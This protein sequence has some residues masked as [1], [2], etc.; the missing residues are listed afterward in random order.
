MNALRDHMVRLALAAVGLGGAR[1]RASY[2]ALVAPGEPEHIAHAFGEASGCALVVRGLLLAAG[3]RPGT[4]VA[5]P[6]FDAS[7]NRCPR[8]TDAIVS[9]A[10]AAE[11]LRP[12][13]L[14]SPQHG[15]IVVMNDYRAGSPGVGRVHL[16]IVVPH[17]PRALARGATD[18]DGSTY[19]RITTVD[20]GERDGGAMGPQLVGRKMRIFNAERSGPPTSI[21][22]PLSHVIDLDAFAARWSN[23]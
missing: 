19:V 1:D 4:L 23:S 6:T 18:G 21:N 2:L 20:G 5:R 13:S 22:G 12:G 7:L 3:I 14:V 17:P 9:L 11:S 10:R 16:A 15:D 8:L